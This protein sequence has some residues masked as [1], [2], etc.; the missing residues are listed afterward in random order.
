MLSSHQRKLTTYLLQSNKNFWTGRFKILKAKSNV[1]CS[2]WLT[3]PYSS[4]V[5]GYEQQFWPNRKVLF[6]W[7]WWSI[8]ATFHDCLTIGPIQLFLSFYYRA[9][10]PKATL[11][12]VPWVQSPVTEKFFYQ[13]WR[14]R[15]DRAKDRSFEKKIR[16]KIASLSPS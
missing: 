6:L 14:E 3:K 1:P 10:W 11:I 8:M 9:P 7:Y 5:D 13:K 16:P 12:R 2:G 15:L 4:L